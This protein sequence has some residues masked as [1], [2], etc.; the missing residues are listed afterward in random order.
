MSATGLYPEPAEAS[1]HSGNKVKFVCWLIKHAMETSKG[2][3]DKAAQ[4]LALTVH[5]DE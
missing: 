2:S 1:R 5:G 4:I 3:G